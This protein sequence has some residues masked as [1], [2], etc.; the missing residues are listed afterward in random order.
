MRAPLVL[1][2]TLAACAPSVPASSP[3]QA[4]APDPRSGDVKLA[5]DLL[6]RRIAPGIWQHVTL[7]DAQIPANGVLLETADGGTVL[8]DTGWTAAQTSALVEWAQRTL[9]RPVRRAVFTHSHSDRAGGRAVLAARG[10]PIASLALTRKLLEREGAPLP[11][12]IPGLTAGPVRDPSG[13]ELLYPGA[14]HTSDNIVVYFPAQRVLFGGW[15]LKADTA[16]TVGNVADADVEHWPRA[17]ARVRATYPEV[18]T[19]VPGHGAVSGATALPWTER[20]ITEKG[21]AAK[22]RALSPSR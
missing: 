9:R 21:R 20:L 22:A 18:R 12:S 16:T 1:L 17:V 14:G 10:I 5:P 3:G 2:L 19:V 11:D 6:V 4:A 8:F 13:F 7:N 15:L